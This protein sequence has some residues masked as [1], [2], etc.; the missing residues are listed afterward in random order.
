MELHPNLPDASVIIIFHNEARSALLRTVYSVLDR[1]PPHLL[2]EVILVDDFSN[3]GEQKNSS[4]RRRSNAFAIEH[5]KQALENDIKH[6]E[7]VR[8]IRAEKREGLIRARLK[9]AVDAKGKVL[10]FL[11]SH[12]E[13]AEGKTTPL[14]RE[15][16]LGRNRLFVFRLARATARSDRTKS[17]SGRRAVD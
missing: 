7:K 15:N 10:I 16:S 6:L 8:I 13:C 9:G 2:K 11:D 3:Q 1:S 17:Q 4:S 12:C 5:L 14:R